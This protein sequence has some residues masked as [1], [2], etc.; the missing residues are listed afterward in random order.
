M[1]K[2]PTYEELE[3][4]VREL[5]KISV[6]GSEKIQVSGID[7]EWNVDNGTCTFENLPVAMMSID[8]TLAGLM[9]GVQAMVGT[10]RFR[11][12][13]QSEGRKSVKADWQIISQFSDF[14]E[15]FKAI[16]NIASVAGWGEWKL[17]SFDENKKQC[18][19]Q[20]RDSWE[21]RYQKSLNVCWGSG[22]LAGKMAGYCSK[23]FNTN[24]WADQTALIAKGD[25]FDEFV[26]RPSDRSVEKE[27]EN[28]LHTDMATRADMSVALQKLQSEVEERQR[29]EQALRESEDRFRELAELLPETIFEMDTEGNLTFVNRNAF[30]HFGYTPNDF[31]RGL[32]GFDMIFFEDRQKAIDNAKKILNGENVGLSEYTGL[33]KDGSTFPALFRSTAIFREGE[34]VGWRGFVID[35]S[36]I[37][38]LETQLQQAQKMEAI[39]TLAGGIAHDFN[40]ILSAVIGFTELALD[41]VVKGTLLYDNLQEVLI[42]GHRAKDLVKQILTFA[43]Q[44]DAEVKPTKVGTIAKETLKLIRSTIPAS[45]EIK[46]NIN[47]D[48][49]IMA[50]PALVHQIFMNLFTN[51]NHAME[52]EGGVLEIN[53][54]DVEL[55]SAFTRLHS[56]LKPGDYL[57]LSVSDTGTGIS[58]NSIGLIF[59][60][61]FTTKELD[62]GTGMGL[63][64]VHGIVKGY[65]GEITVESE[66]G[67]GTVFTVYLPITKKRIDKKSY[68][69]EGLPLG[70]E[71]ILFVDDEFPI[72]KMNNQALESLG[73]KVTTRTSSIE[74]LEL[75]RSKPDDF[76][77]VITDMTM[78]N[79]NGD[80]L[81]G[82]LMK[83][84][85]DIH[86]ILSTG[87]SKKISDERAAEI[88]I[89]A[90][91][92]KP[93]SKIELAKTIRKVLDEPKVL[94]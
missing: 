94:L 66:M 17:I 58:P 37:K 1:V 30:D 22:M 49:L 41:D 35:I 75:F 24:C 38:Q 31:K 90:F 92:M 33:K 52:D 63:A 70:N 83:I 53:L 45:I 61:Y 73:Y 20:V 13:L 25:G 5:E 85:P 8:T 87:Y 34:P 3:Q 44:S 56:E 15:G 36:K 10:E 91:A 84:R 59:E 65:G 11:L 19:F 2:K 51:A 82:E 16:A 28:L 18:Q 79:M 89:K 26:V 6:Y 7:I 54:A 43:R 50:N 74:A 23:I 72:V 62:V 46:Q 48:S 80:H 88:G 77:L 60:P 32:N 47:S 93:I 71:R 9:S 68:P 64:M 21:G 29:A 81:A 27:I 55:D 42:A 78:P 14:K 57:R 86:I 67:K 69:M 12:A 39:G 40:N 76:D 4:R